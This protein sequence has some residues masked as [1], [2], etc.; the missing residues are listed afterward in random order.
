MLKICCAIQNASFHAIFFH[1]S[2]TTAGAEPEPS[3]APKRIRSQRLTP[4]CTMLEVIMRR[5]RE[6]LESGEDV[7][8]DM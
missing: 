3:S 5:R 8:G 2:S 1:Q 4:L 7:E 6:L